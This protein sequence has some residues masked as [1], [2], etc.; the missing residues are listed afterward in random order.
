M[1]LLEQEHFYKT[2]FKYSYEH[3]FKH[4]IRLYQMAET[5]TDITKAI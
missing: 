4:S 2:R 5:K 1:L 3:K